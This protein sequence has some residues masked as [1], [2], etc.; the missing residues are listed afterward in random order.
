MQARVKQS[1]V[2]GVFHQGF[3]VICTHSLN[4]KAAPI[5]ILAVSQLHSVA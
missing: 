3:I 2:F 4:L 5:S 1:G